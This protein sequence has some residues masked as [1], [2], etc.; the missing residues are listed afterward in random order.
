M[1][2]SIMPYLPIIYRNKQVAVEVGPGRLVLRP[3]RLDDACIGTAER[4]AHIVLDKLPE[5]PL[6]GVGVNFAFVEN[7]PGP[8]LVELF[9]FR[10][11]PALTEGGWGIQERRLVQ[12][13]SRGHRSEPDIRVQRAGEHHH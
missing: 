12:G 6:I 8:E 7:N 11:D 2:I 1:L 9:N 4:M 10:D 3:R 13:G 5:T